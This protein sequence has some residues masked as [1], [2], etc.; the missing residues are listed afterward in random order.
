M[1]RILRLE[2]IWVTN[3]QMPS[4]A[5]TRVLK[6]VK[7]YIINVFCAEHTVY[8]C[9]L[10]FIHCF[11][12]GSGFCS[13]LQR[14]SRYQQKVSFFFQ[15]FLL[16]SYRRYIYISLE[17]KQVVKNPKTLEIKVFQNF[18]ACWCKDPDSNL[19][20]TNN[21]GSGT[22][23]NFTDPDMDAEHCIKLYWPMLFSSL[24][25]NNTLCS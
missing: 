8:T 9:S 25:V 13:F 5:K 24:A 10:Q 23:K 15:I 7:M 3:V 16:I 11:Q 4:I 6:R 21:Y 2:V 22:P 18:L 12:S 14:V 20:R 17:R 19:D 1:L